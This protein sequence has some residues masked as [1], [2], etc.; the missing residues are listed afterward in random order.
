[1][2]LIFLVKKFSHCAKIKSQKFCIV[3]QFVFF[4]EITW[5]IQ[6]FIYQMQHKYI[7]LQLYVFQDLTVGL[8]T[9]SL[10]IIHS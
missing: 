5:F 8:L 6:Y 1:M 2:R 3:V 10:S 9:F 4:P 7:N